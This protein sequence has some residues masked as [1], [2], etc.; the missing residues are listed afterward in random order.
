MHYVSF[1]IGGYS[2]YEGRSLV[3]RSW[4]WGTY[5]GFLGV[6]V[7][8][9]PSHTHDHLM[10]L[11]RV[12]TCPPIVDA[13]IKISWQFVDYMVRKVGWNRMKLSWK[14]AAWHVPS[15]MHMLS[16]CTA[17]AVEYP[18]KM[19][20]V[21]PCLIS[22]DSQANKRSLKYSNPHEFISTWQGARP[23]VIAQV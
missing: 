3:S 17:S 1:L 10:H 2:S 23:M 19:D 6:V 13:C 15:L 22:A 21:F 14:Q 8:G 9:V 11:P 5:H 18:V 7:E 12:H 4:G 20:Q 16:S